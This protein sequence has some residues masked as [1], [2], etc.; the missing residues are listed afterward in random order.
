MSVRIKILTAVY[1]FIL[2]GIVVL[3]NF[4]G[5]RYLLSFVRFFPYGD[6]IGHF[7]LMGGFSLMLNLA[8][9]AKTF[10]LGPFDF[11]LGSVI[12]LILVTIEEVS[13][14]FVRGRSFDWGDLVVDFAGIF[15]FGR[16][17]RLICRKFFNKRETDGSV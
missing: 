13:Q 9:N 8:L 2:A 1:V 7:V 11:L 10:R 14:I 15:L 17:A 3:A 5:T 4:K 16:L 6:K 12:A